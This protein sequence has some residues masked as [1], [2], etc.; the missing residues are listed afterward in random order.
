MEL[1]PASFPALFS[2]DSPPFSLGC[3]LVPDCHIID[4][5]NNLTLAINLSLEVVCTPYNAESVQ[6]VQFVSGD[7]N[8]TVWNHLPDYT[9]L[10]PVK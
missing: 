9:V 10:A 6:L 2:S 5:G 8:F 4:A 3:K 1:A 7:L